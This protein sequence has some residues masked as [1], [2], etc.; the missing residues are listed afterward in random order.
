MSAR[1]AVVEV[2]GHYTIHVGELTLKQLDDVAYLV[3]TKRW[4]QVVATTYV[5]LKGNDPNVTREYV[6]GLRSGDVT[7]VSDKDNA[8][9]DEDGG[10]DTVPLEN[11]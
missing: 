11:G 9:D 7:L 10:G 6:A 5:A 4:G 2:D 8:D 1:P 3:K